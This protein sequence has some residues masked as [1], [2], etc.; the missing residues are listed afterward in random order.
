MKRAVLYV[1]AAAVA[2][3]VSVGAREVQTVSGE[4]IAL[5]CYLKNK[6]D[7]TGAAHK[8]CAVAN[9]RQGQPLAIL[10]GT[11][12]YII[13]GDWTKNKNEKL[14]DFVA[15]KVNATGDVVEMNGKKLI[16]LTDV[17]TAK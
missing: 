4:L 10:A 3:G 16:N 12:F 14:I 8:D 11:E 1:L 2:L 17:S 7:A 13:K 6:A 9:A 15:M 5:N